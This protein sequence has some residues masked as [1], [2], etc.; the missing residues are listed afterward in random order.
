MFS[1]SASHAHERGE[2]TM[3]VG[4]L[5]SFTS[6][7]I[8]L[9]VSCSDSRAESGDDRPQ[10]KEQEVRRRIDEAAADGFSGA[11][12]VVDRG[13]P[14]A[15]KGYGLADRADGV[16]NTVDTAF[17]VGSI[18]KVMTA[19]AIYALDEAGTLSVSDSLAD[20]LPDVPPDKATITLRQVVQHRAGLAEY[21]DTTGDFERLTRAEARARILG[22]ELLFE[23]GSDEAYSNSGYTLLADVVEAVSGERFTDYVRHALF[24]PAGMSRSG[25]YSDDLWKTVDTAVGYDASTFGAN[26]PATWPLTWA[27]I[28]NG[29]LVST[30]VDL[31][32]WS[33]ALWDGRVLGPDALEALRTDCLASEAVT[34][35]GETVYSAAGAGDY[36]LAGAMIE[37][38]SVQT[39][40]VIAT[41][42]AEVFAIEELAVDL[43]TLLLE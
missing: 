34:L 14:L 43:V 39:R 29:G 9:T 40:I 28:G 12:L 37:V 42:S 22:Q 23:P 25:F 32:R 24:V 19:A 38:P 17:D 1:W 30:V 5:S 35:E 18:M 41:N 36:G 20:V 6:V 10:R 8:A 26:D 3:N 15:S 33:T 31:D 4:R 21:H 7:L 2:R 16:A 11:V 13:T 27:L